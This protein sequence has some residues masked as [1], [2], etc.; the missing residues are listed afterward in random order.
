LIEVISKITLSVRGY[1]A[2]T[3]KREALSWIFLRRKTNL[4]NYDY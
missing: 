2:L 1:V 3:K 4:Q